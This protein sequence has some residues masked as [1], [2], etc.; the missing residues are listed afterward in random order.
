MTI[1]RRIRAA[2]AAIP[3]PCALAMRR[4][5]TIG[6]MGLIEDVRFEAGHATV[7]LCLTDSAC[8]HFG[9]MQRFVADVLANFP[10]VTSVTVDQTLTELWTPDR[11]A[12]A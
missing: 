7:T 5:T 8:V 12:E 3:E 11:M 6:Q 2:V 9:A 4:P 10:E 1:E